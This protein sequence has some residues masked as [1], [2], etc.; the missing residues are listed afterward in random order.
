MARLLLILVIQ[1][2]IFVL[3]L[4]WGISLRVS[5]FILSRDFRRG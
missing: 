3:G 4:K 1:P 5:N 2:M